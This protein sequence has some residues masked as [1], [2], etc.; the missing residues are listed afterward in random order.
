MTEETTKKVAVPETLT[1]LGAAFQ[2]LATSKKNV[3][4]AAG[5]AA[6]SHAAALGIDP[7]LVF[8]GTLASILGIAGKD[9]ATALRKP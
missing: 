2:Y 8:I 3:A 5:L 6:H 4:L 9:F 1:K 7:K